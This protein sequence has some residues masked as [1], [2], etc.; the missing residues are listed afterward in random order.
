MIKRII[1]ILGNIFSYIAN[2]KLFDIPLLIAHLV[3]SAVVGYCASLILIGFPCSIYESIAKKKV[4]DEK[5]IKIVAICFI[6]VLWGKLLY[7]LST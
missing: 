4:N 2:I 5:V 1:D 6:V 7:E 3:L